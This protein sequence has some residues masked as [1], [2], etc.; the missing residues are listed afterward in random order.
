MQM[1]TIRQV[2]TAVLVASTFSASAAL[3]QETDTFT[4]NGT[5]AEGRTVILHNVNGQR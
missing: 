1:Q 4:W 5:I 2:V 3:A